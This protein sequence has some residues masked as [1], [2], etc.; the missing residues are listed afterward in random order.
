MAFAGNGVGRAGAPTGP[1]G[2]RIGRPPTPLPADGRQ[3]GELIGGQLTLM[4]LYWFTLTLRL[5]RYHDGCAHP[6]IEPTTA[7]PM[8]KAKPERNAVPTT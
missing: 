4:L 3:T 2:G 8:A 6:Y 1:P 7:T 5:P